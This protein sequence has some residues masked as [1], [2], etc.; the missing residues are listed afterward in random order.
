MLQNLY[1]P[2]RGL[3]LLPGIF[4][5]AVNFYGQ[6]IIDLTVAQQLDSIH[7]PLDQTAADQGRF[8]DQ[9]AARKAFE[10]PDVD[11]GDFLAEDIRETTLGQAAMDRHLATLET[12]PNPSTGTTVV[13]FRPSSG[14]C[15]LAGSDPAPKSF[16]GPA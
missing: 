15:P 9:A 5:D 12:R 3:D 4:A 13:S 16:F 8:I 10:I 1:V 2:A 14:R 11:G 7:T 6:G